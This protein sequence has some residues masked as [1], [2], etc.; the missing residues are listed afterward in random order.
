MFVCRGLVTGFCLV[1]LV[2]GSVISD[3]AKTADADPKSKVSLVDVKL[4]GGALQLQVPADWKQK[5]LRSRILEREFAVPKSD[6]DTTDGRLTMMRSGGSV[7]DNINRWMGQF[8]QPNGKATKDVAK[9]MEKKIHGQDAVVVSI[10]G[11]YTESMGGGPFAP[12]K[13]VKRPDYQMLG[14]I[15]QTKASG[16]YFFKLYGPKKTVAKAEKQFMAMLESV[17]STTK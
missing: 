17:Q 8:S 4:A 1:L 3:D 16:Q 13:K 2:A 14:G 15:I 10:P 11:T 6:G 9:I 12:G 5:P 7:K